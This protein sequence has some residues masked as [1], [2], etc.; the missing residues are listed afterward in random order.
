MLNSAHEW[1]FFLYGNMRRLI[2]ITIELFMLLCILYLLNI[3]NYKFLKYLI[4]FV[5]LIKDM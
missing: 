3:N 1:E 5:T 2:M 4:F